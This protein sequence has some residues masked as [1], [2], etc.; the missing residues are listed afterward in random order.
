MRLSRIA[1]KW[2]DI[3]TFVWKCDCEEKLTNLK[4]PIFLEYVNS[5]KTKRKLHC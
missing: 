3:G 5:I 1:A 4:T 2:I